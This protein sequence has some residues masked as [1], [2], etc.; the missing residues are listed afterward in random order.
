MLVGVRDNVFEV[1][2]VNKGDLSGDLYHLHRSHRFKCVFINLLTSR[3]HNRSAN[4]SFLLPRPCADHRRFQP[5][6]LITG[7][8]DKIQLAVGQYVRWLHCKACTPGNCTLFWAHFPPT[9]KLLDC[10]PC[11]ARTGSMI[12]QGVHVAHALAD[13]PA[14]LVSAIPIR[15]SGRRGP[16]DRTPRAGVGRPGSADLVEPLFF[17]FVW[18]LTFF[19]F[20]FSF[21]V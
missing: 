3:D 4:F 20:P 7:L 2:S 17:A 16:R 18:L 14:P 6:Y 1:G 19:S 9:N 12:I 11:Q 8:G 10:V 21:S 5:N 15:R 13:R